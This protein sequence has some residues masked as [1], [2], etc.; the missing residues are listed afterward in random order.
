[1]HI[2]VYFGSQPILGVVAVGTM[3]KRKE[4]YFSVKETW[5]NISATKDTMG[6]ARASDLIEQMHFLF[7][8]IVK[9]RYLI[10]LADDPYVELVLGNYKATT[11][12]LEKK[13]NPEWDQ[14]FAFKEER[15][16]ASE[17]EIV[18]KNRAD[19]TT[20][21]VGKLSFIVSEAPLRVPPDSPLAPQWYC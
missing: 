1:M 21:I 13:S 15:I 19:V 10:G 18:V 8:K 11:K 3:A 5:P 6:P 2:C 12:F 17:F 16:Q 4:E 7:V 14:V 20:E 9:G